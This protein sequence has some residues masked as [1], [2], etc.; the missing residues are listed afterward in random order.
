MPEEGRTQEDHLRQ[1][2]CSASNYHLKKGKKSE[3]ECT[4]ED[5]CF[6]TTLLRTLQKP[7]EVGKKDHLR[8]KK[9]EEVANE[10]HLRK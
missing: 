7:I 10:D 6:L 2:L 8:N 1:Q 4:K 9:S 5:G 3:E